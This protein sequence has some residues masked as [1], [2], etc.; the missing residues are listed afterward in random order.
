MKSA[1]A[2]ARAEAAEDLR[3]LGRTAK[4]AAALLTGLLKDA[5]AAGAVCGGVGVVTG[6]AE[7]IRTRCR[8]CWRG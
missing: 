8:C 7:D 4:S 5:R 2:G 1:D 6:H 3:T